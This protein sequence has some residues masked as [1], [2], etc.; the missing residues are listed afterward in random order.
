MNG[1]PTPLFIFE[2]ANNHMG[3]VTH[4]LRIIRE[5]RAI[6]RA[7]KFKFAFKMQYRHLDTFIHPDYRRRTDLKYVKRFL[8]TRLDEAALKELKAEI[9]RQGFISICTPFDEAS[10]AMIEEHGFDVIKVASCSFTDWPL[11]ERIVKTDK[12]II[13]STAGVP[14]DQIDKAVSFFQHRKRLF[15]LMHCVA[16]YPTAAGNLQL[17]QIDF[18]QARYPHVPVGYST[19]ED[20]SGPG[21]IQLAIA[22]GAVLF[23]K[24]VGIPV[25]DHPLNAY[26]ANPAQLAAWLQ[27]AREAYAMCGVEERRHD[28]SAKEEQDLRGLRRGVFARHPVAAGEEIRPADIF[29]AFPTST[30]QVTANE[31]SKYIRYVA[32]QAIGANQPVMAADVSALDTRQQVFEIVQQAKA[33]LQQ[34]GVA[35]PGETDFEISHHYGI[36]RFA[37]Y[38]LIMITVVNREYC[39]KLLI[40]LPGQKHPE[41]YHRH[42][43]ETFHVLHGDLAVQ[44]DGVTAVHHKGDVVVVERGMKH[45]FESSTGAVI[46]EI[47][48]THYQDDSYY[49]DPAIAANRNRKT[50]LTYWME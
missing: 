40:V 18:L 35:V 22:K 7:F 21:S 31:F 36:E 33:I 13:A 46:E 10:V 38:G 39:K 1:I 14:L 6:S 16:E 32:R 50:F 43:E 41:Q 44:L 42:K 26:S 4:G 24:H 17:N 12:P 3:D 27:A 49:T 15:A 20:P 2:L 47:S 5:C 48:S 30:G 8:E 37:E 28:F 34:S 9:D 23:E 19:H 11:L 45:S 29:F 25:P